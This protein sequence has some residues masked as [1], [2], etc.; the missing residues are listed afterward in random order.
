[1]LRFLCNYLLFRPL[2]PYLT[3]CFSGATVIVLIIATLLAPYSATAQANQ[4]Q[5]TSSIQTGADQLDLYLP[6]LQG[7]RVGMV[8]NHTSRIGRTHLVD[9]LIARGIAIKTIFA[10]EH[11]FRGQATDGE[12]ISSGR[13]PRTGIMITSL[14]GKNYKPTP[15]QMDSLDVV[16]FDIQDVGA[17]FY[18]YTSTMHYVMEACAETNKP[19]IVLDRPNPNGHYVDGPVLDPKFK[20]FVGLNPIPVVY[21]L[22]IGELARMI[23]GEGWL[24]GSKTCSLTVVPLKNYTRQT[25]YVLPVPPSPNLPNQQAVLLYPSL[26]FFEGTV[27]SVGR[28]TDKQFQVIGSPYTKYGPYTFTPVDRPGAMNPPLEGQLCYGLDL[29]NATISRQGLMLNYFF[30]F[31]KQASDKSKFF[32]ANNGI[33]RL[34]GTNQLRLQLLA[35]VSESKIRESWQPA[36]N[37]YKQIRKKYLLYN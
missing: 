33:D 8:V 29:T 9:S 21:G 13:D 7:K 1:M 16:V 22:T 11:G 28:G 31:F 27:V 12:E 35:G 10:P 18:T 37:A 25:P 6:A 17:R 14:Y 15:K 20:S 19:M 26:C 24:A 23:N 36:L 2:S 30:D 5:T 4:S 34:A 32:L 3:I